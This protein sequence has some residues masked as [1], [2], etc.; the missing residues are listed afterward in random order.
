M[1]KK[2]IQILDRKLKKFHWLLN[3]SATVSRETTRSRAKKPQQ[4]GVLAVWQEVVLVSSDR[5]PRCSRRQKRNGKRAFCRV[6][7]DHY[8][9]VLVKRGRRLLY[10]P[11]SGSVWSI[12][13]SSV[14]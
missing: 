13:T 6:S 12:S 3:F 7:Y 4:V 5:S 10:L 9:I 14:Q 8:L 2:K 1:F 11:C